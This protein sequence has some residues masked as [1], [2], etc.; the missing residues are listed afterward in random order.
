[1]NEAAEMMFGF[2]WLNLNLTQ[3]ITL[4]YRI[5]RIVYFETIILISTSTVHLML[6]PNQ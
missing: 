2:V 4:F 1:M 3:N 6:I 5:H